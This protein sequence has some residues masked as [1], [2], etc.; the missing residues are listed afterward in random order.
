ML[1]LASDSVDKS[2]I[3]YTELSGL[4]CS[5]TF[6]VSKYSSEQP[7]YVVLYAYNNAE[8]ETIRSSTAVY[9]DTTPPMNDGLL[10]V[11]PNFGEQNYTDDSAENSQTAKAVCIWE[12]D[13]IQLKFPTSYDD[14]SEIAEYQL[15]I[16]WTP[17][18]DSVFAFHKVTVEIKDDGWV[19]YNLPLLN[20]INSLSRK[21]YY[22]TIRAVN[23][24]GLYFDVS[25]SPVYFKSDQTTLSSWVYDGDNKLKDREYQAF[26][27]VFDGNAFFGINCPMKLVEWSIEGSDGIVI[28]SFMEINVNY[29]NNSYSFT[30]D[31]VTYDNETYRITVRGI[32]YSGQTHVIKS[33]GLIVTKRQL[34]PGIVREGVEGLLPLS[35]QESLTSL[36]FYFEGFGDGTDEQEIEYFEVALGSN[37]KYA[38]TR[39][40]IVPFTTIGL[41][42]SYEFVNLSLIS[43]TQTYFTTVRAHAV[44]GA[45][46]EATSNGIVVG[47][48]HAILPGQIHQT[49]F[50]YNT[51]FLS[52]YWVEFESNVPITKYEWA[53]GTVAHD[54]SFLQSLC[55]DRTDPHESDFDVFGFVDLETGT[56]G[57]ADQLSLEHGKR[58]FVTIRVTDESDM[59]ITVVSKVPTVV[60]TTPPIVNDIT[61]GV[62]ESRLNLPIQDEYIAYLSQGSSLMV[63]WK[64]FMDAESGIK[65]YEIGIFR[66]V[67]CSSANLVDSDVVVEYIEAGLKNEFT[68]ENINLDSNVSYIAKIKATN[69][70]G[71]TVIA[72][73]NPILVDTYELS[74]GQVKDGTSWENDLVF[75]S[76]RTKLSG[77]L[78][79]SYLQ[80]NKEVTTPC[81]SNKFYSFFTPNDDWSNN[82]FT[83][84]NGLE[85]TALEYLSSNAEI[86]ND[87]GLTITARFQSSGKK[88]VV[89]GV[90]HAL[91]SD[92]NWRKSISLMVR[93]ADGDASLVNYTVTS[94]LILE[95][96]NEELLVEYDPTVISESSLADYKALGLQ[97]HSQNGT[98]QHKLILWTKEST[99]HSK[100]KTASIEIMMNSSIA[101]KIE[102]EFYYEMH[103]LYMKTKVE[104]RVNDIL[105]LV[106]HD[107]PQ[108]NAGSKFIIH[109]FNREG[110]IPYCDL[111][112]INPPAVTAS[113]FDV[114]LPTEVSEVCEYGT[115]FH[116]W[117]SPIVQIKGGI[118]TSTTSADIKPLEVIRLYI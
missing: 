57:Y 13:V 105:T 63:S 12:T 55:E 68:F 33:D 67:K 95:S 31:Q 85:S 78:A 100:V 1:S 83:E 43:E 34:S 101:H 97:I 38:N 94:L 91:L 109:V 75:Q 80:P 45:V 112:C 82:P 86:N 17:S 32:D 56:Y 84:F 35:Y 48:T 9:V 92:F 111:G 28:K 40:D 104:V 49:E 11:I 107:I 20:T 62:E 37:K 87:T 88:Q 51:T 52:A 118:G 19:Y 50:Q 4:S 16:G 24:V 47:L 39:S 93:P 115:P 89:S 23:N 73:S 25:S 42:K 61:V 8:L 6:D 65:S 108:F 36:L 3:T 71:L 66:L 64:N 103:G 44:S 110:Y 14:D 98:D 10:Y 2:R 102:F 74:A 69:K 27:D 29:E 59:C 60:D 106:L 21:P 72:K 81:P 77:V 70:A 76:D 113:F 116:S 99:I 79:L 90:Y 15:A 18:D 114:S 41:E 117:S 53:L 96:S 30:T 26:T 46:A 7:F 58:Y 5:V 22:F 54:D